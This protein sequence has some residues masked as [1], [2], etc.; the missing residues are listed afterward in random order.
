LFGHINSQYSHDPGY[1]LS[2]HETILL[3]VKAIE[4]LSVFFDQFRADLGLE[5]GRLL[6]L[7]LGRLLHY[8]YK[9]FIFFMEGISLKDDG[10]CGMWEAG[11]C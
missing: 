5:L 4:D 2:Q 6:L 8:Y 7:C 3:L 10:C 1:I 11:I 9:A